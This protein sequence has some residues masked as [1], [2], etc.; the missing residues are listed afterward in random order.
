MLKL[1]VEKNGI[2]ISVTTKNRAYFFFVC[3][4]ALGIRLAPTTDPEPGIV[5][6]CGYDLER[7]V[8]EWGRLSRLKGQRSGR[9]SP[10]SSPGN[11]Y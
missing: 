9:H 8:A 11:S 4:R 5:E 10:A 2:L 1:L 6:M 3:T 7:I